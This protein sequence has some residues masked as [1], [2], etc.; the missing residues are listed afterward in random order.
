VILGK[1][2]WRALATTWFPFTVHAAIIE[3][4]TELFHRWGGLASPASG[5]RRE[6][7]LPRRLTQRRGRPRDDHG[8]RHGTCRGARKRRQAGEIALRTARECGTDRKTVRRHY[9][10]AEQCGLGA[11]AE[12]TE[13]VVANVAS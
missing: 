12:L 2:E 3:G 1:S 9:E 6:R 8:R 5:T 4:A 10:P 11:G 13:E 7:D